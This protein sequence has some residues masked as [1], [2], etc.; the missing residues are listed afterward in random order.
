MF[1]HVTVQSKYAENGTDYAFL[2]I[3]GITVWITE[4]HVFRV[5]FKLGPLEDVQ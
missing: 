2:K 1:F 3:V 5:P 4:F